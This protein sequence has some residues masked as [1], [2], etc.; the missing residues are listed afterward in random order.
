[1]ERSA[2]GRP[3]TAARMPPIGRLS[4]SLRAPR[5][6]LKAARAALAFVRGRRRLRIL[7]LVATV[8]LLL[9]GGGWLLLRHSSLVAVRHVQVS[10]VHGPETKAIEAALV[11]AGHRMSTLDVRLG[12][13]RSAVAPFRVVREVNA[14]A[15]FPHGLHITVVEQPPVAALTVGGSR[16]AVAADGVVLGP[17]LLSPSLPTIT[18]S[19]MPAAGQRLHD[20]ALI[21]PLTILGAAP[22]A[23]AGVVSRVYSGPKGLTVV[24]GGGLLAY[25]GDAGRP[26]AKWLSLARVLADPSSAGASYVDVRLP[27]R[28]AAGFP[29]GTSPPAA[30]QSETGTS[31]TQTPAA[32]EGT[33][34][35]LA[36]G[37]ARNNPGLA[38]SGTEPESA[39]RSG[40]GT[41]GSTGESTSSG[42]SEGT[43]AKHEEGGETT[44]EGGR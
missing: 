25:F 43:S 2:A 11:A 36:A 26:H 42:G 3:G 18:A 1:M 34:E 17:A 21:G 33:V 28:P 40:S 6:A 15:S 27:E 31:T 5:N 20:G 39:S 9:L 19:Y 32:S 16:T 12:A 4:V 35:S 14:S 23:L 24:M 38:S 30:S 29:P 22:R 41:T 44:P 8:L 13:L 7:L 37:L 10:G